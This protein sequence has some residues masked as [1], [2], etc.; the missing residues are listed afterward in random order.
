MPV[1]SL[2]SAFYLLLAVGLIVCERRCGMEY[3]EWLGMRLV[4][5][6]AAA[7]VWRAVLDLWQRAALPKDGPK[8][9]VDFDL[10]SFNIYVIF[11]ALALAH[12]FSQTVT[13]PW[14]ADAILLLGSGV[15]PPLVSLL[16]ALSAYALYRLR[17]SKEGD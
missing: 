15:A 7:L 3:G 13:L 16:A 11:M 14:R 1:V 5:A 2:V 8:P 4:A 10:W 12:H 9:S 6:V 17:R